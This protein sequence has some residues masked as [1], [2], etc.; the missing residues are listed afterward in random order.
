MRS[1]QEGRSFARCANLLRMYREGFMGKYGFYEAVDYTPSRLPHGQTTPAVVKSFMAHHE[2]MSFLSLAY[3]LLDRPMQR[4]FIADPKFQAAELLLQERVPK[5]VPFHPHSTESFGMIR[6]PS[7]REALFRVFNTP[8]TP[9]P[10]VHLLSNGRYSVMI[11]NAGGGYS[12]WKDLAVTRWR[13]DT[14]RDSTGTFCYIRDLTGGDMWSVGYQP[15]MKMPRHYEAIFS[16]GKDFPAKIS[17]S[18][19]LIESMVIF[20]DIKLDEPISDEVF[21]IPKDAQ[22]YNPNSLTAMFDEM[23]ANE[24]ADLGEGRQG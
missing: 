5:S 9:M 19:G 13:E 10:E 11:T 12:R 8:H 16:Q 21:D 20:R 14:T 18:G 15:M 3:V 22:K 1:A 24:G 4:R 17:F 6:T 7:E 23:V 2:G